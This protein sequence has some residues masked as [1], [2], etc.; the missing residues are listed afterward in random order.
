MNRVELL[1][2]VLRVK[3]GELASGKAVVNLRLESDNQGRKVKVEAAAWDEAAKPL[4]YVREG[5]T[6][7]VVGVLAN[8]KDR[9]KH[10]TEDKWVEQWIVHLNISQTL[11]V[12]GAPPG[13]APAPPPDDFGFPAGADDDIPF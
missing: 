10:D 11:F 3:P 6:V 13:A 1:G 8:K 7:R 12:N 9:R 5:D 2:K 4:W